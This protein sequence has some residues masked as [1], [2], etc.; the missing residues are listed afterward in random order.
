MKPVVRRRLLIAAAGV[1]VVAVLG[2]LVGDDETSAEGYRASG[3]VDVT[4]GSPEGRTWRTL[5]SEAG[6]D[7]AAFPPPVLSTSNGWCLGFAR[8]DFAGAPRPSVARCV[9]ADQL[10]DIEPDEMFTAISVRAGT[11]VWHLVG[12]GR[13]VDEVVVKTSAGDVPANR[14]HLDERHAVLRLPAAGAITELGWVDGRLRH[15]CAVSAPDAA[16]TGEFC[17]RRPE[18]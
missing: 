1:G 7:R 12:F 11:D 14:V 15:R 4:T 8:L 5:R 13:P 6:P 9:S 16:S 3:S 17:A 18:G 10:P 2:M